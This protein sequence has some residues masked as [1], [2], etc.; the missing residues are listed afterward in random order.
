MSKVRIGI[1]VEAEL[2]RTVDRQARVRGASR[3]AVIEDWLRA[4]ALADAREQLDLA[5]EAYY[6]SLTPAQRRDDAAMGRAASQA[7]RKLH[8][9]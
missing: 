5:A 6:R 7:A 8:I 1:T 2:L 9:D 4:A 3:S